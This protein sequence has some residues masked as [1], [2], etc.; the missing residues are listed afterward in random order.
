MTQDVVGLAGIDRPEWP[1][2]GSGQ[3]VPAKGLFDRAGQ[4]GMIV[5]GQEEATLSTAEERR[6]TFAGVLFG[7]WP[8]G[9]T[10]QKPL[11]TSA[12]GRKCA[13]PK[14]GR[15]LSIYNHEA[16]CHNHRDQMAE[17]QKRKTPI[18]FGA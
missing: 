11:K 1:P 3:S 7:A 8:V 16:Y 12:E 17:E 18:H 5:A 15:I 14:C 10:M 13:F 2:D 9:V 6:K 4:C